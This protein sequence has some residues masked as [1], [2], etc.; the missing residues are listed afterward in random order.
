MNLRLFGYL[1]L[2]QALC[3]S[4]A[5]QE[6]SEALDSTSSKKLDYIRPIEGKDELLD[7]ELVKKGKVLI[8]YGDC[9]SCHTYEKRAK[10]P[11]FQDIAKRYPRNQVYVDLLAQKVISGGK[12][13]WGNP[14][15]DPHP[16]LQESDAKAMVSYILSLE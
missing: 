14:V 15:M 10:G 16:N 11:A 9:N 2:L 3:Y 5:R 12:G 7:L 4:C 13:S 6:K 8:S 1:I